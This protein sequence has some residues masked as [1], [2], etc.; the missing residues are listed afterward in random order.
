MIIV[1]GG[2]GF[3]GSNIAKHLSDRGEHV[4]I[5]DTFGEDERWQNLKHTQLED[6]V[7]PDELFEFLKTHEEE[8]TAVIHMGA[9]SATTETD[10]DLIIDNNFKLSKDLFDWCAHYQKRFIYASSAATY[11]DGSKGFEDQDDLKELKKFTPLNAYAWSKHAFDRYVIAQRDAGNLLPSQWVG[12]KFFN[13]YGPNEYHKGTMLSVAWQVYQQI[14]DGTSPA[15]LFRSHHKDYAHGG[16]L[17]DFIYV[18][19][20]VTVIEWL[21]EKATVSGIFNVGTGQARSFKDLATACFKALGQQ[22]RIDY[23]DMPERLRDRYQYYTQAS[24]GKLQAAG[25]NHKMT[26]LEDGVRDYLENYL[27]QQDPYL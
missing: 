7:A 24:M 14:K 19:D 25:F 1:T 17:R 27:L 15:R 4:V 6:I 11:G 9:I 13:V 10:V 5:N 18:K 12:L 8:I 26:S 20:C 16:Q 21:L 2:A 23:V 22:P 3:I